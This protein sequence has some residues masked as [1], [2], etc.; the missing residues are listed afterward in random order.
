[1][2]TFAYGVLTKRRAAAKNRQTPP[3]DVSTYVDTVAALVPAEVL[4]LHGVILT[5]TTKIGSDNAGNQTTVI[6]EPR[7]LFWSFF[8]LLGLSIVL[9]MAGRVREKM[10]WM[11]I[12]RAL[13]PPSAFIAW[14]MLQRATAFDALK[15]QLGD[16][17]RSVI[18]LFAAVLLAAVSKILAPKT[19]ENEQQETPKPYPGQ[20]AL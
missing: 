3:P 16:I 2:S 10:D 12:F 14:T 1:M 13:I 17:P 15:L 11:D 20:E 6:Q 4:A 5:L 7:V 9:Y 18:G 8:G 19:P